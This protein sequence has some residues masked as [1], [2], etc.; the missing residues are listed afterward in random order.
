MGGGE[1]INQ[2]VGD[3]YLA[4]ESTIRVFHIGDYNKINHLLIGGTAVIFKI[5]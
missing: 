4:L 1:V 5:V 3:V 2:Y